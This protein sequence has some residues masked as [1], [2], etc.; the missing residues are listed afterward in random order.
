MLVTFS[1]KAYANATKERGATILILSSMVESLNPSA[2][3]LA[4]ALATK[5]VPGPGVASHKVTA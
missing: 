1:T 5:D 4:L 2:T 3:S